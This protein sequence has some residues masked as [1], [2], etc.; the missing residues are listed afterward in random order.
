MDQFYFDNK[1]TFT[2]SGARRKAH[3]LSLNITIVDAE[4]KAAT[5]ALKTIAEVYYDFATNTGSE[6]VSGTLEKEQK[7]KR[8]LYK[9][10]NILNQSELEQR[11][12]SEKKRIQ[13]AKSE[14]MAAM[15]KIQVLYLKTQ[16]IDK[17]LKKQRVKQLNSYKTQQN[18]SNKRLAEYIMRKPT[19]LT[20][21][22]MSYKE[23]RSSF[24]SNSKKLTQ[25]EKFYKTKGKVGLS[26]FRRP[27][28]DNIEH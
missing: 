28:A 6:E 1:E 23:K 25:S 27:T 8:K 19:D 16:Q 7:V 17:K 22:R 10:L 14:T 24:A 9:K 11:L 13:D 21:K 5:E 26:K 18:G 15:W 4:L 3:R 12:N 2:V 20:Q